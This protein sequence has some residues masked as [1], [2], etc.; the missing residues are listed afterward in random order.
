MNTEQKNNLGEMIEE[1]LK[2]NFNR[3]NISEKMNNLSLRVI[4][5]SIAGG[6]WMLV[7]QNLGIIPVTQNVYIKGGMITDIEN[8]IGVRV[9]GN[10][11]VEGSVSVDNTV[12]I[13]IEAINGHRDAFFNNPLRGDHNK[14][15]RL[16]VVTQ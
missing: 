15:Y 2:K 14:Y 4:L 8:N 1:D 12:D 13:N 6:I 3:N 16:P 11:N 5:L 9:R 7:L 10:V